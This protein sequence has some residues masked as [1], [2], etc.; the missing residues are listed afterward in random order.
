MCFHSTSLCN[1]TAEHPK[2]KASKPFQNK[3][4]GSKASF[5]RKQTHKSPAPDSFVCGGQI[6]DASIRR[7]KDGRT[8]G[9]T[10]FFG[11]G[12]AAVQLHGVQKKKRKKKKAIPNK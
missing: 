7:W 3:S 8:D 5:E 1:I 12:V 9:R 2:Q 10:L 6:T 4:T 11:K